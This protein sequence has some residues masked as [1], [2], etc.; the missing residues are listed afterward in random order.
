[1]NDGWP[2]SGQIIRV[3]AL[4]DYNTRVVLLGTTLL[5]IAGGFVGVFLLLRRRSLTA[6]VVSHATFPGIALAFLIC[7]ALAPGSGKSTP[8]LLS[9]AF[10]TGILGL[11]CTTLI[12]RYTRVKEDAAQALV[13]SVFFGAGVCLFTVIQSIPAGN[14]AGLGQF[15]Y[16]KAASMIA[17][18]VRLIAWGSLAVAV[19][20]LLLFKELTLI[21]FD[22]EFAAA[23]GWPVVL[24]DLLLLGMVTSVTVIGLQSVGMLLVVAL[25]VI[26]ATA[27]RCWT[28]N[29]RSM[30]LISAA[31]GGWSA[32][33]GVLLSALLP[34]LAA[35]A[36][37]VLAGTGMFIV[38]ILIGTRS[39]IL[40]RA[41]HRFRRDRAIARDHLL[42]AMFEAIEPRCQPSADL[43]EQLPLHAV[44]FAEL[45]ANR[46]WSPARLRKLVRRA[47]RLGL[48]V[49]FGDAGIKL[50]ERGADAACRVVRNHRLWEIYLIE[51]ADRSPSRVDRDA[52]DIE[53]FLGPEIAGR[54]EKL[55]TERSS[56]AFMPPSPHVIPTATVPGAGP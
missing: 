21:S 56:P 3:L 1:M 13:L 2:D 54:L 24:L 51:F 28:H 15:I 38:S 41:I 10:A 29:L 33:L 40:A 47:Q 46:S 23:Q 8:A 39:G 18:D 42:R 49:E 45:Q 14:S 6:D 22:E 35:G 7:E 48:V 36:V 52:D 16:G 27:A 31:I 34:R 44:R 19:I 4:Q 20:F 53:H 37:I 9:G 26:P 43:G 30:A 55:L 50:T 17:A 5:G 11:I 12:Q 25:M 32:I